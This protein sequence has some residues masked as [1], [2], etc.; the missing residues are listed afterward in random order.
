MYIVVMQSQTQR[1][2]EQAIS[3]AIWRGGGGIVIGLLC[4]NRLMLA[5]GF[6]SPTNPSWQS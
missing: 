6:G 2:A 3:S 4:I 1:K 5:E